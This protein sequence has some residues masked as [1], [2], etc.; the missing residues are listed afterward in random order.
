MKASLSIC[1][2]VAVLNVLWAQEHSDLSAGT[3]QTAWESF[4]TLRSLQPL[5]P[6]PKKLLYFLHIPR[7]AGR[8]F[9]TCFLKQAHP[10][11]R[12]IQALHSTLYAKIVNCQQGCAASTRNAHAC[13]DQHLLRGPATQAM[14]QEL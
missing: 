7:T 9:G 13:L 10:P 3:C 4:V 8:T 2:A 5:E 1:L 12:Y 6:D 14:R 11:S